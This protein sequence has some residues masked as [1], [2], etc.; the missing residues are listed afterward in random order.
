MTVWKPKGSRFYYCSFQVNGQRFSGSTKLRNEQDATAFEKRWKAAEIRKRDL[1]GAAYGRDMTVLAAFDRLVKEKAQENGRSPYRERDLDWLV[2]QLGP[3]TKLSEIDAAKLAELVAARGRMYRFDDAKYG[4]VRRGTIVQSVLR[5]LSALL[6]Q[7]R[8]VWKI[9]LP[10]M[11]KVATYF[12]GDPYARTRELSIREELTLLPE[13][14][15]YA[16]LVEFILLTG[17][18]RESAL[19]K[20]CEVYLEEGRIKV[21]VKGDKVLELEITP[22]VEEILKANLRDNP[23]EYVFTYAKKTKAGVARKPIT[24]AGFA[25]A[26]NAATGRAGIEDLIIHDLRRTAGARMYRATGNIGAVSKFLGHASIVVTAKHYVH[27]T[28]NDVKLAMLAAAEDRKR[29]LAKA[30]AN[31]GQA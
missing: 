27:I 19:L 31:L 21:P 9:P 6:H 8:D 3:D 12:K 20:R 22:D 4:Q 2:E 13:C 15:D 18:R 24:A 29:L 5:P 11:P 10:D 25:S 28:P 23:T 26:F 30:R 16:P 17:L 1:L 14:G 7:A